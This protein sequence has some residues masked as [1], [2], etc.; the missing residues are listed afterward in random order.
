MISRRMHCSLLEWKFKR[1]VQARYNSAF[2]KLT[3]IVH[4]PPTEGEE[5]DY[6]DKWMRFLDMMCYS[7][8]ET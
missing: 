6:Y 8:C 7:S 5:K 4:Y 1:L 2:T 3:V